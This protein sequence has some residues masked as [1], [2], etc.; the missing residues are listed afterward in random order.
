MFQVIGVF[1]LLTG[2]IGYSICFCQ[3][4]RS[5]LRC[6][7]EM[8]RMYELFYSQV[9]YCLAAFPEACITV[10]DH[11]EEP[12]AG[13]LQHIYEETKKNTGKP[14]PQIWEE[15]IELAFSQFPLKKEDKILLTE[16]SRS[17]GYADQELQ[18]QAIDNQMSALLSRIE[19]IE[20]H[21]AEREKMAMSFGVMGGL[22]LV[23]LLL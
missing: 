12:F 21:M 10:K 5:R 4:M 16:F 23:I 8:K 2:T 7:Y 11:L 18:K 20:K 13:L 14:F 9:S 19:K 6:L 17:F 3:D 1:L 15:Q 22:L